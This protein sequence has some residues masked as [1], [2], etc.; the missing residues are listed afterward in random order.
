MYAF[1]FYYFLCTKVCNPTLNAEGNTIYSHSPFICPSGTYFSQQL[2]TCVHATAE[3]SCADQVLYYAQTEARL[4]DSVE[5]APVTNSIVVP[6][7]NEH[8]PVSSEVSSK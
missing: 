1:I 5:H 8:I 2:L 3:Y 6:A 4:A 7:V